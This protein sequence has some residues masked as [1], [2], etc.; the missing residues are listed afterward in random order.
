MSFRSLAWSLLKSSA[1]Q[2]DNSRAT[3]KPHWLKQANGRETWV[4]R[5]SEYRLWSDYWVGLLEFG[6]G[7]LETIQG[8]KRAATAETEEKPVDTLKN[9]EA[10]LETSRRAIEASV[11]VVQDPVDIG[12]IAV[13]NEYVY[14]PLR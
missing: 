9:A 13:L 2:R 10:A 6:I 4:V 14:H 8:V 3:W 12:S 11:G 5:D 7:Y 1:C